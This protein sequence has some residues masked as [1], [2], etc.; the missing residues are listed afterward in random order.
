MPQIISFL[1]KS[2]HSFSSSIILS[3]NK[4]GYHLV[5]CAKSNTYVETIG[6]HADS[7]HMWVKDSY[8]EDFKHSFDLQVRKALRHMPI[9]FAQL[10]FDITKEP[11][12]GKTRSLYIF[13]T[14]GEKYD[15]EFHFLNVCLIARNKQIPLMA[16]PLLVGEGAAK[17]TIN[18]L[19][20][21]QTLF[22]RI[23]LAIGK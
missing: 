20:Y 1:Q 7:L 12:Y 9:S 15:G 21:C 23:R 14:I 10:A 6:E 8:E 4:I 3:L 11:F 19:E 5:Q 2:F 18:L 16:L 17:K 22:T 13:N